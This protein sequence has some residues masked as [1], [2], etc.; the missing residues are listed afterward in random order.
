VSTH[1]FDKGPRKKEIPSEF[2]FIIFTKNR[3]G[4][5]EPSNIICLL[6]EKKHET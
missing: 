4:F 1:A 2:V 6:L 3:G 5:H